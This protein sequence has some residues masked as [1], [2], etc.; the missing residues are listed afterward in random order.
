MERENTD[1]GIVSLSA[2]AVHAEALICSA[3][4]PWLIAAREAA[5]AGEVRRQAVVVARVDQERH[6]PVEQI[7]D[8]GD[9]VFQAVHRERDMAAVEMT[10]VQDP[11]ACRVDDR[12][13]V[14]AVQFV[15]DGP[16]HP[17]QGIG[18][19]ADHM[20]RAADRVAILQALAVLRRLDRLASPS[21]ATPPP[22]AGRRAA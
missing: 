3:L 19:H 2:S 8:V 9:G 12:I 20:G 4:R 14:G 21:A 11:F 17:R 7:G 13:V 16:A 5:R 18:K 6:L 1:A 10:A 15:F 22:V